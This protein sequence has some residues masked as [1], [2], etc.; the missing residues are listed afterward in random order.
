MT[1]YRDTLGKSRK[2]AITSNEPT[3]QSW[4]QVDIKLD[5]RASLAD[6]M[7]VSN[8]KSLMYTMQIKIVSNIFKERHLEIYFYINHKKSNSHLSLQLADTFFK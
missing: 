8:D 6:P 7:Q 4:H 5:C 3:S 1:Q 2:S